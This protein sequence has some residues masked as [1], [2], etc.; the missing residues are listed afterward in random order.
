MLDMLYIATLAGLTAWMAILLRKKELSVHAVIASYAIAV[1]C[2]D[3]LEVGFNL[4][5]NLYKFPTHLLSDPVMD[6]ELGIIFGDTLIL[7]F[8]F[9]VFVYYGRKHPPWRISLLFAA[10]FIGLEWI[11]VQFG[12]MIYLHWSLTLSAAFYVV[13]FR[14]GAFLAP[15]IADYEP[16][17]PHRIYLL[18]FSHTIIMWI[19]A[20]F[21]SPLLN[22]YQF[23][24]SVFEDHMAD[25]RFMDL[26]SGDVL[27]LL[28]TICVPWLPARWKM[29][30]YAG[31]ACIG[32]AFAYYAHYK[33][34]LIYHQ[35]NHLFMALRYIVPVFLVM[36][37][38]R[39]ESEYRMRSV[40]GQKTA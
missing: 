30:A 33:G 4:L 25:C 21:A 8:A 32:I 13:G 40:R 7:P 15:R 34:W 28:I 3:M 27:T 29:P 1:F 19:G 6:N 23:R 14:L 9:I 12:Y 16:P 24:P 20:I 10:L 36:L 2:A 11:Y 26:V 38:D 17:V 5:L 18:C 31:V 37:Y 22:L 35:W 39:W